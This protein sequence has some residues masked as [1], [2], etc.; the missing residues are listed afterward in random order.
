MFFFYR[1]CAFRSVPRFAVSAVPPFLRFSFSCVLRL[2]F[3]VFCVSVFP[4]LLRFLMF[5]FSHWCPILSVS[6]FAVSAVSQFRRFSFSRFLRFSLFVF[7]SFLCFR[8]FYTSQFFLI[9]PF[10][11]CLRSSVSLASQSPLFLYFSVSRF[12]RFFLFSFSSVLCN[13]LSPNVSS[14]VPCSS[15]L[16]CVLSSMSLASQC[17]PFLHFSVSHFRVSHSLSPFCPVCVSPFLLVACDSRLRFVFSFPRR[18]SVLCFFIFPLFQL[19]VFSYLLRSC[20]SPCLCFLFRMFFFSRVSVSF[21]LRSVV[22]PVF[23]FLCCFFFLRFASRSFLVCSVRS[24]PS[25]TWLR[26]FVRSFRVFFVS[27]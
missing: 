17:S 20:S 9:S 10:L 19:F 1:A 12:L 16:V 21:L 26:P 2:T 22:S 14:F 5:V 25:S 18:F 27:S 4:K 15:F 13:L 23:L 6:G 7:S 3:L 11:I 8:L 24:S